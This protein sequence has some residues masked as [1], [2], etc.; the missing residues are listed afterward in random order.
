MLEAARYGGPE[1]F[2]KEAPSTLGR[3]IGCD[4]TIFL[5]FDDQF[6]VRAP[7]HVRDFAST[8]RYQRGMD[9]IFTKTNGIYVDTL[10]FSAAERDRLPFFRE[11]LR[12][13]GITSTLVAAVHLHGRVTGVIHLCRMGKTT[14]FSMT[15]QR[16]AQPLLDSIGALHAALSPPGPLGLPRR[17]GSRP[18]L[19]LTE[20]EWQIA[21]FVS[22]GLHN[23][24]IA[25]EIGR[26]THTVRHHLESIF[27][28]CGVLQR[29]D[30][31]A[32][33]RSLPSP[34]RALEHEHRRTLRIIQKVQAFL[35]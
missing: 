2:Q 31:A 32:L 26:S 35:V 5:T 1:E 14:P 10:M 25:L 4:E 22:R 13:T 24:Q 29:T 15:D 16:R 23:R 7:R 12:P 34:F 30:L 21:E 18:P 27:A 17:S 11:L 20:R 19:D 28:K 6:Y 9:R 8:R 3:L 33:V